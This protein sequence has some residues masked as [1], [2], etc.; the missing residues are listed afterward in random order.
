MEDK[1]GDEEDGYDEILIPGDYK[2]SGQIVDDW[3]YAEFVT[4]VPAGVHVVAVIDCCHSGTASKW[5]H[6]L[7]RRKSFRLP[8]SHVCFTIIAVDLP[9]VCNPGE[10]ELK[11]DSGFKVPTSNGTSKKKDKKEKKPKKKDKKEKKAKKAPKKKIPKKKVVESESE[12]E[13]EE[14][15]AEEEEEEEEYVEEV[16]EKK[17]KK[18]KL[19]GFGRK[20]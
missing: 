12:E 16:E 18:K 9:Y 10:H 14:A 17:K 6:S 1:D 4:K 13:E 5:I 20:K 3:I 2:E 7:R 19:F 15:P 8:M 11:R